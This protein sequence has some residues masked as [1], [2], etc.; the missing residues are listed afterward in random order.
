MNALRKR[1]PEEGC[2]PIAVSRPLLRWKKRSVG[3]TVTALLLPPEGVPAPVMHQ[4]TGAYLAEY[5][6]GIRDG[7]ILDAIRYHASGKENMNALGKLVYL[8]DLLEEARAF[9]GI[10]VL[11]AAFWKDLDLCMTL[12][13]HNQL[14]YLKSTGKQVYP[15]TE[16]AYRWLLRE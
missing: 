10:E 5:A 15:L 7:E 1:S 13:L 14:A 2:I 3:N 11:R 6:F 12:S 4:Y 9:T 8:A 16:C